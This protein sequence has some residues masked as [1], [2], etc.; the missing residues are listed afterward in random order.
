MAR[1]NNKAVNPFR[2][3]QRSTT[4]KEAVVIKREGIACKRVVTSKVESPLKLVQLV[5]WGL[6]GDQTSKR[7]GFLRAINRGLKFL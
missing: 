6:T 5:V 2:I 1:V 7:S 4:E 3:F